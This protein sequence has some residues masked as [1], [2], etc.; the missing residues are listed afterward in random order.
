MLRHFAVSSFAVAGLLTIA[1]APAD[2]GQST[3]TWKYWNPNMAQ[4]A[5]PYWHTPHGGGYARFG[6]RHPAYQGYR[7]GY[8]GHSRPPYGHA[9]GYRRHSPGW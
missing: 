5:P 9:Y 4:A 7:G 3:V 1:T 6:Y 2:A 8:G